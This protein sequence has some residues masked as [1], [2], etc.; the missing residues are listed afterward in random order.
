MD[1]ILLDSDILIDHLRGYEPARQY[2]KRFEAGEVQGYLSIITV[3]ELAAGQMRQEEET[4]IQQLLALFT[5]IDLDFVIAWRGGEIRR[6]YQTRLADALISEQ[7]LTTTLGPLVPA[8]WPLSPS[9]P[10]LVSLLGLL[11][12]VL[13]GAL[14]NLGNLGVDGAMAVPTLLDVGRRPPGGT[15]PQSS[16]ASSGETP[17]ESPEA[18]QRSPP[19][20]E[21]TLRKWTGGL[22]KRHSF[23]TPFLPPTPREH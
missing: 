22:R 3:A 19:Q 11:T 18:P 8:V 7:I 9:S 6:H 12:L 14:V 16:G 15:T 17:S 13:D 10:A 21:K 5:P 4:K 1:K 20:G 23:L 2:L